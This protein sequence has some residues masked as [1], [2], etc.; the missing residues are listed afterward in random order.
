MTDLLPYGTTIDL[1]SCDR[2]PIHT[3]G[4]IQSHGVLLVI[5]PASSEILQVSENVTAHLGREPSALLGKSYRAILDIDGGRAV[6]AAATNQELVDNPALIASCKV[7]ERGPFDLI[8]HLHHGDLLLELEPSTLPAEG[9][10][11]Y[12]AVTRRIIMR[13]QAAEGTHAFCQTLAEEIRVLSGYDRVMI[14]RFLED[15]SGEVFAESMAPDRGLAPYLSLRYPASDIPVQA[16]AL[17]LTNGVRMLPDAK[18]RQAKL[19]PEL[20]P[21][22]GAP[23]DMSRTFLRGASQMYTEYLTNMGVRASLTLAISVS[24]KLWGL[25]ACHHYEVRAIPYAARSACEMLAHVASLQIADKQRMDDADLERRS[26]EALQQI[27][28]R[29]GRYDEIEAALTDSP[30]DAQ[31][32]FAC[33]GAAIVGPGTAVRL[34]ATPSDADL[35]KLTAWL[36]R[37]QTETVHATHK[38]AADM[39]ATWEAG[40][41]ASGVL[42][43]RL[44]RG[45]Y[46]L[47]FRPEVIE[48]V[49]WA[50]DP[51]KPVEYGSFGDRLSPRKSFEVWQESVRGMSHAWRPFEISAARRLGAALTDL[52]VRRTDALAALNVNLAQRNEEL[53]AFA[54]V[55]SHDL[56]EPL[57]G[58]TNHATFLL[59][60]AAGRLTEEDERRIRSIVRLADRMRS[61]IDSLLRYAR[62]GRVQLDLDSFPMDTC[63]D[64]A[65]ADVHGRVTESG[66][67]IIVQ[68]P[69]PV[70][71]G[72]H[73]AIS[74]IYTNLLSNALKYTERPAPRIE[75]GVRSS[76]EE[77][78]PA[79]AQ[80]A[81]AFFVRDDGI[82]L[83]AR[84]AEDVFRL[85]RR[86]H[87]P[88]RYGGGS[89]AGLTIVRKIVDRHGGDVWLDSIPGQGTTAWF[90]VPRGARTEDLAE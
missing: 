54:Y 11:G 53:D 48:T 68:R 71:V 58:L 17:F 36:D 69:M 84:Y 63:V 40:A 61:L 33:G 6:D 73:T 23:V 44:G 77:G 49:R 18:Y 60:E 79:R 55:A 19:E 86:L 81:L 41:V 72:D 62:L 42:S 25:V 90:T 15:W 64:A 16:R 83:P 26:A 51:N 37:T 87:A 34:G 14:Y 56:K 43:L 29:L 35:R 9:F 4:Q 2:E 10:M 80:G 21:R 32:L 20:H 7:A 76:G 12:H 22:T 74:E 39:N 27:V 57:R 70:I 47:W 3:P 59:E 85:F 31:S 50:G 5:D 66:A 67:A 30:V 75:V 78:Y 89:G 46:V 28:E 38:L 82:G 52:L 13:L 88:G 24:G 8:A 45:R 1:T 65:L